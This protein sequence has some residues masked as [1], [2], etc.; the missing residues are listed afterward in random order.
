[1]VAN[2]SHI[3]VPFASQLSTTERINTIVL[4]YE[5]IIQQALPFEK[6]QALIS[7]I[8]QLVC[9]PAYLGIKRSDDAT[10]TQQ[11]LEALVDVI[12][13]LAQPI[14][15]AT[16]KQLLVQLQ[17]LLAIESTTKS[18]VILKC[19]QAFI[20]TL[21]KVLNLP[22]TAQNKRLLLRALAGILGNGTRAQ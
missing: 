16:R 9:L 17:G 20:N 14:D 3:T 2:S 22:L 10:V 6:K 1:M 11:K 13:Q 4:V 19:G 15:D 21:T 12:E 18:S 7:A 5:A 8:S